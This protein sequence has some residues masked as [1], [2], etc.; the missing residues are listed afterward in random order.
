M[1]I[2]LHNLASL[3]SALML[4]LALATP[5]IADAPQPK[6]QLI[7]GFV[8][9]T[10]RQFGI[11]MLV[12]ETWTSVDLGDTRGYYPP[13]SAGQ[14]NRVLLYAGNLNVTTNALSPSTEIMGL[15]Q[16]QQQP[17]LDDWTTGRERFWQG[18]G[19]SYNL[20]R[21]TPAL[22]IYSVV[23]VSG[24]TDLVA[25]VLDQGQ[26]LVVSL[27]GH[28]SYGTKNSLVSNGLLDDFVTMVSSA[29]AAAATSP[30]SGAP[31]GG[32]RNAGPTPLASVSPAALGAIS[33]LLVCT[34]RE[35]RLLWRLSL[36]R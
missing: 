25:Y 8:A 5:A 20:E 33:P 26:L 23:P 7:A 34:S 36:S 10:D 28:G 15:Q 29:K 31:P 24:E 4:L 17:S 21:K 9:N 32:I 12:P 1:K 13:G 22:A 30:G 2:G 27:S 3:L 6:S 19:A 35:E 18:I 11:Q 14:T 16:F